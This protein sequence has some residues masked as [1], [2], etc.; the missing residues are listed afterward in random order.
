[1]VYKCCDI[2]NHQSFAICI[3]QRGKEVTVSELIEDLTK[4]LFIPLAFSH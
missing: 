4:I 2:L 1:M 3:G